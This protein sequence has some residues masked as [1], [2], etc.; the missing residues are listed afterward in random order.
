VLNYL[1]KTGQLEG[2]FGKKGALNLLRHVI[3]KE[4]W[5]R[6]GLY[7]PNRFFIHLSISKIYPYLKDELQPEIHAIKEHLLKSQKSDG[8]FES[9]NKVNKKD[10]IQ[11]TIYATLAML[12][13][14]EAGKDIP[15]VNIE[16]SIVFIINQR[17]KE[18]FWKGGVFFSGG[19]VVRNALYF[20]S[21]A[22]TTALAAQCL[23]KYLLLN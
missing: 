14:K 5:S 10:P 15:M 11:S 4:R 9:R 1:G 22:Y 17:N 21:E 2:S 3:K 19:T 16:K 8:S 20:K 23:Q 6:A 13:L 7:Y 18:N 12:N